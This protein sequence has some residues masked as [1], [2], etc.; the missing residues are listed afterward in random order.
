M[1]KGERERERGRKRERE[2]EREREREGEREGERERDRE[3]GRE[4][5]MKERERVQ[6]SE[7]ARPRREMRWPLKKWSLL[8]PR[9]NVPGDYE[10]LYSGNGT[11]LYAVCN[12][13]LYSTIRGVSLD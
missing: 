7:W 1:R 4:R 3:R 10:R 5:D 13:H 2:G 11:I 6:I 9:T 12:L 8:S